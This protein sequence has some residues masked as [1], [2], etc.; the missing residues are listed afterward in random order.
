MFRVYIQVQLL[1]PAKSQLT[2]NKKCFGTPVSTSA[3]KHDVVIIFP[4][5]NH[6][7]FL[8]K[9]LWGQLQRLLQD[10]H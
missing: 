8:L 1:L 2:S 9:L 6:F 5:N 10:T 4:R 7:K 3:V